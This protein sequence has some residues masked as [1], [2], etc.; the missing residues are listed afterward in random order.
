MTGFRHLG[1]TVPKNA[2]QVF[3]VKPVETPSKKPAPNL[4][5]LQ[6]VMPVIKLKIFMF[7]A[8]EGQ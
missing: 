4:L 3:W 8:S 2:N 1:N 7:T 5:Q 6:F